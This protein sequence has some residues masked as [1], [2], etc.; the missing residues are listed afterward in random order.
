M[1]NDQLEQQV[2][3][4]LH[5]FFDAEDDDGVK[6]FLDVKKIPRI[7]DDIRLLREGMEK[8]NEKLDPVIDIFSS[9]QGFN[10]VSRWI[11]KNMGILGGAI[12]SLYVIIEFF[13][14]VAK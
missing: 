11:L 1:E 14:R 8:M 5:K 9:V 6:R 7:C 10:G 3:K 12:L 2:H 13:R 4:A